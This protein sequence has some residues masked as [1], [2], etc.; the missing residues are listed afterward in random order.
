MLSLLDKREEFRPFEYEKA[1]KFVV[2]QNSHHWIH[3]EIEV[4]SDVAQYN[5]EFTDAE[6]HGI[7]T[8]LKLFTKYETRVGN[9]WT[10]VI[11]NRF[12]KPE[13]QMMAQVF[14]AMEVEHALFYDK[15]NEALGLSTKEFHLSF[16][17][18]PSMLARDKFIGEMLNKGRNGSLEDLAI[19]LG[20]FSMV[21]GVLLYSSFAFLLS[22]QQ[23]AQAKLKNVAGTGLAYSVR[24]E[25]LH[26]EG[27]SWLYNTLMKEYSEID[28]E[29][30]E[31]KLVEIAKSSY[32]IEAMI[33]DNI[34]S[35]GKIEGITDTQL[36]N[37]VK[38]RINKKLKD[39]NID[40]IYEVSYNPIATWFYKVINSLE[41]AD[42]FSQNSTSYTNNW[43]FSK[44]K[45][46]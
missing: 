4:D 36:K 12:Q 37:F 15:L 3:N 1:Y 17:E 34:F 43:N 40:S 31:K 14:G 29:K 39:I 25:N 22:F 38:S 45:E 44:I 30:V 18:D 11:Y 32:E 21:E 6:K 28:K 10:D 20:T 35:K 41:V 19:A 13:I 26:A 24:D 9:Y 16:M 2:D 27:G 8:V 7:T 33:I 5:T 46:W 23:Q 42:F